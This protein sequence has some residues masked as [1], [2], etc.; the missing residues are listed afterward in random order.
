MLIGDPYSFA[1]RCDVVDAWNHSTFWINGIFEIYIHGKKYPNVLRETELRTNVSFL[2]SGFQKEMK[3]L[4]DKFFDKINSELLNS[5]LYN[6]FISSKLMINLESSEMDDLGVNM[7]FFFNNK[8]D[9]IALFYKG[10]LNLFN[11]IRGKY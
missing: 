7:I 6:Y 8:N 10:G 4:P 1:I 3:A 2:I 9:F 11:I 5:E